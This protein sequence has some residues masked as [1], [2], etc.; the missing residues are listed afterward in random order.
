LFLSQTVN[1]ARNDEYN[2]HSLVCNTDLGPL[3]VMQ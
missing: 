3:G 1:V 2:R